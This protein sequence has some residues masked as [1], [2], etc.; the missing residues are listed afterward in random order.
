MADR[1]YDD[2]NAPES[3]GPAGGLGESLHHL[4]REAEPLVVLAGP[5]AARDRGERRRARRRATAA[6]VVTALAL[7]VGTWQLLPR[8]DSDG[9]GTHTAPP[10][11][12][13]TPDPSA[14]APTTRRDEIAAGLLAPTSLP[15]AKKW[16]WAESPEAAARKFPMACAVPMLDG[17]TAEVSRYF[18]ARS[19]DAY[20]HQVVVSFPDAAGATGAANRLVKEVGPKCG[21]AFTGSSTSVAEGRSV[22]GSSGASKLHTGVAVWVQNTD[23]YLSVLVIDSPRSPL[24]WSADSGL[25]GPRPGGCMAAGLGRLASGFPSVQSSP[26]THGGADSGAGT[27]KNTADAC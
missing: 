9:G 22:R 26:V 7:G 5:Q 19:I 4:A 21:M 23:R 18:R 8:L 3:E 11:A 6:G 1:P 12:S 13:A 20:A 24:T 15:Y 25:D 2:V 16:Q 10:A 14:T 17:A 27:A